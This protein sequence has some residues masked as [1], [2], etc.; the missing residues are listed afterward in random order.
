MSNATTES[1]EQEIGEKLLASLSGSK[2]LESHDRPLG[3]SPMGIFVKPTMKS[4]RQLQRHVER[5]AY[6]GYKRGQSGS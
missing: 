3:T 2:P 1:R 4:T 6:L 5:E